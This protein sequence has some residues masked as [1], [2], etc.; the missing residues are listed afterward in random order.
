MEDSLLSEGGAAS[1]D[2]G[3]VDLA[4]RLDSLLTYPSLGRLLEGDDRALVND[5]RGR[6]MKRL[7]AFERVVRQ[8]NP[9]DAARAARVVRA[10]TLTIDFLA[11]LESG[12]GKG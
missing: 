8:G 9:Q 7:R 5:M 10:Y 11:E 12:R 3:S 4:S 6:L 2:V 1:A